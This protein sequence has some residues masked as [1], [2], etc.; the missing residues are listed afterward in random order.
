MNGGE[1]MEIEKKL[2]EVREKAGL[3][4][5]QVALSAMVSR[6]TVSN[7]ENGRSLPDIVSILKLSELYSIS[8]DELLKGDQK[9]QKKLEKDANIAQANKTVILVTA[10]VTLFSLAVYLV[11]VFVG[12]P[13]LDFCENAIRWVLFAVGVVFAVTYLINLNKNNRFDFLK[14]VFTMKKLQFLSILLILVSI[15]FLW[16]PILPHSKIPELV[17]IVSAVL[18]LICGAASLFFKDK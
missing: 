7:W 10:A 14:G 15:W 2:R 8:I 13:L 11:S 4:Q 9:M 17:C 18:G 6:Q 5:E 3:T 16:A 12:D 1:R